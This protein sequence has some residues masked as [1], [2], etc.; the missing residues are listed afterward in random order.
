MEGNDGVA[1]DSSREPAF[2]RLER[3]L[4]L[5]LS[6]KA[7]GTPSSKVLELHATRDIWVVIDRD[8]DKRSHRNS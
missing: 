1:P 3:F 4:E 6:N 8:Q 7:I 2:E 5:R